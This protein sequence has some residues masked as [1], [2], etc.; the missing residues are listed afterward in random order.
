MAH[1]YLYFKAKFISLD[2]GWNVHLKFCECVKTLTKFVFQ[3]LTTSTMQCKNSHPQLQ[4]KIC[5]EMNLGDVLLNDINIQMWESYY[6]RD[7]NY[8]RILFRCFIYH[9][10]GQILKS[11]P[12]KDL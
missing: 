6:T 9:L 12:I 7:I 2:D 8:V 4:V 1:S 5:V 3:S 10:Y 11:Y